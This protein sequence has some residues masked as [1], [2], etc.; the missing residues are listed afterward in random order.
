MFRKEL[1]WKES[2][3]KLESAKLM[4]R[5]LALERRSLLYN[6]KKGKSDV[7]VSVMVCLLICLWRCTALI[8]LQRGIDCRHLRVSIGLRYRDP[9][10]SRKWSSQDSSHVW[11][12]EAEVYFPKRSDN[13]VEAYMFWSSPQDCP[14]SQF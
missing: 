11:L 10:F 6:G 4:K 1:T 2:L 8:C 3:K 9:P 12:I 5:K 14:R 13:S 7:Y